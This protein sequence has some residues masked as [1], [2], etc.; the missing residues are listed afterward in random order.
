MV[1][2]N[3]V[4]KNINKKMYKKCMNIKNLLQSQNYSKNFIKPSY[5]I[6]ILFFFKKYLAIPILFVHQLKI[7]KMYL[8]WLYIGT[9]TLSLHNIVNHLGRSHT[10]QSL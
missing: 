10:K 7:L 5:Y 9:H 3:V 8:A 2:T 4:I 1:I 6:K